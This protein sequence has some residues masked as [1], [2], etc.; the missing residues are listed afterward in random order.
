MKKRNAPHVVVVGSS[1]TDM[2]V[3]TPKLPEP[4]QT[5]TGGSFY[6][7]AGGKGANQ[8]VA[9]ARSGGGRAR[10]TFVGAF[11][12]DDLGRAAARGLKLDGIDCRHTTTVAGAASGVALIL[13]GAN[14]E[15][16]ISVAPG[17]ND[18]LRPEHVARAKKAIAG[19]DVLLAQLENPVATIRR[20]LALAR[21]AGVPTM[22]NPAPAPA[23]P[24]PGPMLGQV[25]ILTPNETEF[26]ALTGSPIDGKRGE[27]TAKKLARSLGRALIVTVGPA[28]VRAFMRDGGSFAVPAFKVK[29]VDT[30]AAG[31]AFSGALA[32]GVAEGRD[33]RGAIEFAS[34]VAA[35]SVTRPGA[36]PSLPK[37]S[38]AEALLRRKRPR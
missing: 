12:D 6:I 35:L 2:V 28:G 26:L 15:N 9:A 21:A 11:G 31:D 24:L 20:A 25:D 36:Q 3:A 33:L 14:G 5:L 23:R 8:A 18:E 34:A 32:L 19:A 22:L 4:G 13:V 1:N 17:A 10:V 29:A 27:A 7:A 16:M 37:R 38:E 30:V